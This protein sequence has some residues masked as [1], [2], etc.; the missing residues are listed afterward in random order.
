MAKPRK[1]RRLDMEMNRSE[2]GRAQ[3]AATCDKDSLTHHM[4]T[5]VD[6]WK[7]ILR[8]DP[9]IRGA[10]VAKQDS[11]LLQSQEEAVELE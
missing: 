8:A 11:T 1:P 10:V 4:S 9:C 6:M 7:D 2:A 5:C 3:Q